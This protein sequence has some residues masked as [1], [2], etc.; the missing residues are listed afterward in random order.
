M[1]NGSSNLAKFVARKKEKLF[2]TIRKVD[3]WHK[4]RVV[5]VLLQ[6]LLLHS[7]PALDKVPKHVT[8]K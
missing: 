6:L 3:L 1:N 2:M 4:K 7:V 5:G 8:L